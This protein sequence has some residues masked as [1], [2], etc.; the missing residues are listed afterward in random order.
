MA[1]DQHERPII[2]TVSGMANKTEASGGAAQSESRRRRLSLTALLA[3]ALAL[4]FL[5]GALVTSSWW[6]WVLTIGWA[7]MGFM[8]LRLRQSE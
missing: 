2:P 7:A 1:A 5:I 4:M 6:M 3:F 8:Y